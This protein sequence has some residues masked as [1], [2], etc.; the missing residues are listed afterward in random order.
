[1]NIEHPANSCHTALMVSGVINADF[2]PNITTDRFYDFTE[3][4]RYGEIENDLGS[5]STIS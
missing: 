2:L 5:E 4:E 1:M 3:E